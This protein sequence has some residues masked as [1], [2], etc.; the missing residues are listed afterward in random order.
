MKKRLMILGA[1]IYQVPL[2]RKAQ[3]L[4]LEAIAVS[5]AGNYPGFAIADRVVELSTTDAEGVLAAA[6]DLRIDGVMTT[7]TDVAVR[8]IGHVCDAL[9]LPGISEAA[10][11]RCT[12]KAAMKEAFAAGGV[13]TSPFEV[14]HDEAGAC[15]AAERLG[16]PVMVK[17]CDVSGSRGV[18][19]VA[20]PAGL[21]AAFA[22]SLGAT[23]TDHVIVEKFV[24]GHEIGVDGFVLDGELALFAPHDK[25]VYRAGDVAIPGGHAFPIAAD[26]AL[27]A[28]ICEQLELIV[29][30][31]GM[32]NCAVNGDF[33]VMPDGQVSVIEVGGRCGAT[34]IPELVSIHF[35]IDYYEQMIRA[36]LG[37]SCDFAPRAA[38]PCMAKLLFSASTGCVTRV[39][40]ERLAA[41]GRETGTV[42]S[43]D[44]VEGDAVSAVHD[45]TDRYGQVI[46]RTGDERVLDDVLR[47]VRSC[48]EVA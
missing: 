13:N 24:P 19:K 20:D 25:F 22:A 33:M 12:D 4:G 34:C 40:A 7:G 15:A 2:I 46:M 48:I 26:D 31:T 16:Y 6:R 47:R 39:D 43:L 18:T 27:L 42:V 5:Y 36:A 23:H 21:S 41:L 14:V 11:L 10:A 8:T 32:D 29:R 38:E 30:A 45:G 1:G 44:V 35:G 3:E 9:G 28:R 37:E 17:A